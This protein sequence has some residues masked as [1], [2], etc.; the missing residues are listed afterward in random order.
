MALLKTHLTRIPHG[1]EEIIFEYPP[2]KGEYEEVVETIELTPL[3]IPFSSQIASLI[4]DAWIY[5]I[6]EYQFKILNSLKKNFI[7][8]FTGNLY[9]PKS[10]DEIA[11]GVILEH[12]P[13]IINGKM[14]M[15]KS[16][17]IKRLY[18]NDS[19]VK[20]VPFG[21]KTG[22]QNWKELEKNQYVIERYGP[23]GAEK[24]AEVASKYKNNPFL[25]CFDSVKQEKVA[26]ST[27]DV[28][29]KGKSLDIC[30]DIFGNFDGDAFGLFEK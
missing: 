13:K 23:E 27:I 16:S 1:E 28:D 21:F 6:G 25:Y 7:W 30:G 3:T 18:E 29:F 26:K 15:D 19:L 10:N 20:F 17:L 8:E 2:F 5:P 22:E 12:N 11:N 24:V 14:T 4:Y 9:L